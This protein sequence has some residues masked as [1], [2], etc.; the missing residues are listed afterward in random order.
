V[1]CSDKIVDFVKYKDDIMIFRM[2]CQRMSKVWRRSGLVSATGQ[3][4]V[5]HTIAFEFYVQATF[6]MYCR[7]SEEDPIRDF[8]PMKIDRI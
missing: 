5:V 3:D 2:L 4:S 6:R 8:Q 1:A 7:I